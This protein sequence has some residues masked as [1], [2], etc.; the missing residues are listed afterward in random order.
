[1]WRRT[2][3]KRQEVMLVVVFWK[4]RSLEWNTSKLVIDLAKSFE[5]AAYRADGLLPASLGRTP[6]HGCVVDDKTSEAD[7]EQS[8]LSLWAE[9]NFERSRSPGSATLLWQLCKQL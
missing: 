5:R 2:V 9:E 8:H 7:D 4:A 3:T 6:G 1:M